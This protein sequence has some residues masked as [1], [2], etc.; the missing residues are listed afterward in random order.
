MYDKIRAI[1]LS[2]LAN[3]SVQDLNTVLFGI[4]ASDFHTTLLKIFKGTSDDFP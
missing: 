4:P 1:K 3:C 2:K